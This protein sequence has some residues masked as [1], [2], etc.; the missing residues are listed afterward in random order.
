MDTSYIAYVSRGGIYA[1]DSE[2]KSLV[3]VFDSTSDESYYGYP[4]WSPTK[5]NVAF[6]SARGNESLQFD[7]YLVKPDGSDLRRLTNG[8]MIEDFVWSPDGQQV[9]FASIKSGKWDIYTIGIDGSNL[10]RLTT[11]GRNRYPLWSPDSKTILYT[12]LSQTSGGIYTVDVQSGS[13]T[14]VTKDD[15]LLPRWLTSD[16]IAFVAQ[17]SRKIWQIYLI[18][19]ISGNRKQIT[20]SV[21]KSVA[22]F[23]FSPDEKIFFL[24]LIT[25]IE[26]CM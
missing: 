3:R 7:I 1:V 6:L 11:T 2:G 14:R 22:K 4:Q 12:S 20:I 21:D 25:Q 17:D 9:A 23:A 10:K 8:L 5:K 16:Q 24:M 26:S 15:E 18:D 13:I 19:R